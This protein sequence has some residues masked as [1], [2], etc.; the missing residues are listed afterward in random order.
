MSMMASRL[1]ELR[2][3]LKPTGNLYLH[4]DPT[5]SHFLKL[6]MDAVFG[7]A[8]FRTEI[9]W[10]RTSAHSDTKQGRKQHGRIHDVLLFYTKNNDWN[11]N[12]VYTE[13]DQ[14]YV[15]DF[16]RFVEPGTG[17]RYRRGD[18]TAAK[19]GGDTSYEWRVKR[20]VGKE[21]LAD[22][23]DEWRSPISGWEYKGVLPLQRALLRILERGNARVFS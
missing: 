19:P 10:K 3:V 16:Y 20:P 17:R 22:L 7:S 18:L 12:P 13:Y 14:E 11:W 2:R 6:L 9:I 4:C 23:S 21:W 8:N 1:V 5:A 15:E